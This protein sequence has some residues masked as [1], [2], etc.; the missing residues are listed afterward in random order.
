MPFTSHTT[1]FVTVA[2][3]IHQKREST[4]CFEHRLQERVA[5]GSMAKY[6]FKVLRR[7]SMEIAAISRGIGMCLH[8]GQK[9]EETKIMV[10]LRMFLHISRARQVTID[11]STKHDTSL[12]KAGNDV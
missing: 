4:D 11:T 8:E 1:L 2:W 3:R 12:Q 5:G 7:R 6:I 9:T 10:P